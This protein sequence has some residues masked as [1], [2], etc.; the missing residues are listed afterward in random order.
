VIA[1]AFRYELPENIGEAVQMLAA[2]DGPPCTVTLAGG[3]VAVAEMTA[4]RRRPALVLDLRRAGLGEIRRE[5]GRIVI[6]ACATYSMLLAC[7][8]VAS[9]LPLL[10]SLAGAITGG[11]QIRNRGTVGGSACHANPASDVP[12]ALVALDATLRCTSAAGTREIPAHAFFPGAFT[13]ALAPGELLAEIVLEP[14]QGRWGY[15]KF[16]L[17]ESSWPIVTAAYVES[18]AGARLSL[19]GA[20]A[21]PLRLTLAAE[22]GEAE[23]AQQVAGAIDAPWSDVLADGEFRRS[24][25]P[26]MA[27]RAYRQQRD[28]PEAV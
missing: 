12:A 10:A 14:Q 16:K 22:D 20:T 19:G 28:T 5:Q 13:T 25:A 7:D 2:G 17:A 4:G 9:A 11:A 6:G 3:T 24:I 23:I 18:G 8:L 21:T 27:R 15:A 26:V 1:R